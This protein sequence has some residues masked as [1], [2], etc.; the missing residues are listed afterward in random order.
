MREIIKNIRLYFIEH[1]IPVLFN[2]CLFIGAILLLRGVGFL[3]EISNKGTE[4]NKTVA[5]IQ[6]EDKSQYEKLQ[7]DYK[8]QLNV[9]I[10]NCKKSNIDQA[11]NMLASNTKLEQ[12]KNVEEFNE[13]F[14][15]KYFSRNAD[16]E[17]ETTNVAMTFKV[18]ILEDSLTS[19]KIE[20]REATTTIVCDVL[21]EENNYKINID[22]IN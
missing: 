18:K 10:S 1:N 8:K 22:S 2:V 15:N 5:I 19:G 21:L 17:I 16:I 13:N 14:I 3:I 12:Y 9:F 20:G 11:Y 7:K 6:N 4:Q